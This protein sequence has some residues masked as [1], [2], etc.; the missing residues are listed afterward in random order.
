MFQALSGLDG[1]ILCTL[2]VTASEHHLRGQIDMI[3]SASVPHGPLDAFSFNYRIL[4]GSSELCK[5]RG[6]PW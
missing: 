1:S 2:L 4:R 5:N 6:V 3:Q